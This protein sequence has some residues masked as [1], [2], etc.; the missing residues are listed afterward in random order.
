MEKLDEIKCKFAA[1]KNFL[2][3]L[4]EEQYSFLKTSTTKEN[5]RID[6]RGFLVSPINHTLE[7]L[8]QEEAR[9]PIRVAIL[10]RGDTRLVI[11]NFLIDKRT[12]LYK[13]NV[14]DLKNG[15]AEIKTT[16][17]LYDCDTIINR[18]SASNKIGITPYDH[19]SLV[20][21]DILSIVNTIN[22][23][24]SVTVNPIIKQKIK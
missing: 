21:S 16:T 10:R 1:L 4:N 22:E 18:S 11:N 12:N 20:E 3:F 2:S 7:V 5:E 9:F 13:N 23:I 24:N 15:E 14:V 19:K 8:I 17:I 6:T